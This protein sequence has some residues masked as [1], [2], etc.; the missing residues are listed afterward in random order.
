MKQFIE[1]IHKFLI[2]KRWSYIG[3]LIIINLFAYSFNLSCYQKL[4]E[5]INISSTYFNVNKIFAAFFVRMLATHFIE[6][7]SKFLLE[8]Q[9]VHIIRSIFKNLIVRIINFKLPYFKNTSMSKINQLWFYLGSVEYL[10]EKLIMDV[11]RILV[12]LSYYVYTV[13]TFSPKALLFAVPANMLLVYLQQPMIKKQYEYQEERTE[14]DLVAKNRFLEATSNIEH[15]KLRNQQD[16]EINRIMSVYDKFVDNKISDIK[17]NHT[18]TYTSKMF[19][20]LLTLII[21]SIGI[22]LLGSSKITASELIYLGAQTHNF[23]FKLKEMREIYNIYNRKQ[24]RINAIYKILT[25]KQLEDITYPAWTINNQNFDIEF[26]NVTFGY[27]QNNHVLKNLNI[28]FDHNK[29]NLLMGPNGSGKSTIIKLLLRLYDLDEQPDKNL[30]TINST[31]IKNISKKNLRSIISFV[32]Q[33][34]KIFNDT[35]IDNIK[36]GLD[37]KEKFDIMNYSELLDLGDWVKKNGGKLCGFMGNDLSGG[38][39]KK[40][41]LLNAMCAKSDVIIFD[42]PSN[43]LDKVALNWFINFAKKLR[44]NLGKTVIIITHDARLKELAD[45]IIDINETN[46]TQ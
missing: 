27:N 29:I 23:Y 41:Q 42:E 15:V 35:I 31:S 45:K 14:L 7:G 28:K 16:Y 17:L 10:I 46:H 3:A 37:S 20:D 4:A 43:A 22:G 34:P 21:Y 40:V 32:S 6:Y 38:E 12:F 13:Y 5:F 25:S 26:K 33:E 44:D 30:I 1:K 24:S 36:Y 2:G 11:P 8:R 18:I 19:N 39:K 9:I